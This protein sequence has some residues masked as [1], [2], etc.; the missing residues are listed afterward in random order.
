M[1][2]TDSGYMTKEELINLTLKQ[3]QDSL[4]TSPECFSIEDHSV[5]CSST[6]SS[7]LW[8]FRVEIDGDSIPD[9]NNANRTVVVTYH[10]SSKQITAQIFFR[11]I[12]NANSTIMPDAIV[13][14]KYNRWPILYK[15]YRDF[16][17]LRKKL[18]K[19][20]V[21]RQNINFLKKLNT[22]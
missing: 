3:L 1:Y 22:I 13:T 6:A 21:S 10:K 12:Y 5:G 4:R 2:Y 18:I 9:P 20:H 14:V 19:L 17:K 8:K 7:I 15:S 16:I 11:E